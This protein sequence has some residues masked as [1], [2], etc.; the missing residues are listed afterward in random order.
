MEAI[1]SQATSSLETVGTDGGSPGMLD[2]GVCSAPLLNGP[3]SF[4]SC[5]HLLFLWQIH[6]PLPYLLTHARYF[7]A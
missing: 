6:C 4:E 7:E 1:L 5:L 3:S 2:P